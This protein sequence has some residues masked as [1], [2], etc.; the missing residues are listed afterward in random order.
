M[1]K[2]VLHWFFAADLFIVYLIF[3]LP[4]KIF[5]NQCSFMNM[6]CIDLLPTACQQDRQQEGNKDFDNWHAA[7]KMHVARLKYR[8][9]N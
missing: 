9:K 3:I 2:C 5:E 1:W 6:Y 8:G 7:G 4:G